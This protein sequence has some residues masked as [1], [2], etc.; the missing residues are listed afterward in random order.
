MPTCL[1]LGSTA[2][3]DH[4]ATASR[5]GKRVKRTIVSK[6]SALLLPMIT[7]NPSRLTFYDNLLRVSR[8]FP[9]RNISTASEPEQTATFKSFALS[10]LET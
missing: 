5:C 10:G 8:E 7:G 2:V 6:A 3:I 1:V 4:V 9:L